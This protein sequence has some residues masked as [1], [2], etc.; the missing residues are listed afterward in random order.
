[1]TETLKVENVLLVPHVREGRKNIHMRAM[2]AEKGSSGQ[3][4]YTGQ[5]QERT[6]ILRV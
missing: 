6:A 4:I 2:W 1:M 5:H 3:G